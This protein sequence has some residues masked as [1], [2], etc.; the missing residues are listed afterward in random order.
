MGTIPKFHCTYSELLTVSGTLLNNAKDNKTIIVQKR[1]KRADPYFSNLE[2][3]IHNAIE[4]YFGLDSA[5]D[6]RAATISL[7]SIMNPAKTDLS[8]FN[9]DI[10]VDYKNDKVKL[11]EILNTLGFKKYYTSATHDNQQDMISLLGQ[12]NKNMTPQLEA[13]IVDK[14]M[15]PDL[16]TRI[17]GYSGTLMN[18]DLVQETAKGKRPEITDEAVT[19]FNG[20]YDEIIGICEEGQNIFKDNEV[21]KNLFVFSKILAALR[22]SNHGGNG[23]GQTPPPPTA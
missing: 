23:G 20:I 2:T 18:A 12:F 13:E 3:R 10:A 15:S 5:K 14:G 1:P 22:G 9:T 21:K 7:Y 8:E 4:K 16:I 11:G 19:E 17:K 6:L